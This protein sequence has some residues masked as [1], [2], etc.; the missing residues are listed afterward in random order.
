MSSNET[1]CLL[2]KMIWLYSSNRNDIFLFCHRKSGIRWI[3]GTYLNIV[4][5]NC[6]NSSFGMC[7]CVA[8]S[9]VRGAPFRRPPLFSGYAASPLYLYRIQSH[10]SQIKVLT[11]SFL[12]EI[13][14]SIQDVCMNN[15]LVGTYSLKSSVAIVHQSTS[16]SSP[17]LWRLSLF[18]R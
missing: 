15:F 11:P 5:F 7:V 6:G 4:S 12:S 10:L 18:S 2:S 17:W 13:C 9:G 1:K 14:K 8:M 16:I 3:C